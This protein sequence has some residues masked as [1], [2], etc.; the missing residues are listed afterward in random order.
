MKYEAL[1]HFE[2]DPTPA[3]VDAMPAGPRKKHKDK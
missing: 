3:E 1:I 2:G